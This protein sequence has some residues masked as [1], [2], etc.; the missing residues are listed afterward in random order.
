[1]S[2]FKR[3]FSSASEENNSKVGWHF[4]TEISMLDGL[5][6]ASY[7]LPVLIFKHSTRCSISRF[8][9]KEFERG[10][11][12]PAEKLQPYFLDLLAHREISN[13][14]ASRFEIA[15]Q[16]PQILVLWQGK[17]IFNASHSD[18]DVKHL[19]KIVAILT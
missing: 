1:M 15:H 9:L 7:H 16:S 8:A 6:D 14:I 10:Y 17:C 19:D 13:A 18:I 2:I 4:L 11:D 5:T 3:I 12:Y